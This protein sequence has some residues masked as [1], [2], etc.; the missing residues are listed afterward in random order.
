MTVTTKSLKWLGA[1]LVGLQISACADSLIPATP[2]P[3]I[4]AVAGGATSRLA[5]TPLPDGNLVSITFAV[6]HADCVGGAGF[7]Y[8]IN[9]VTLGGNAATNGCSCQDNELKVTFNDPA[10]IAAWV[11]GGQNTLSV[12][13]SGAANLAVG[14][15]RAEVT[16]TVGSAHLVVFDAAP[17]GDA[18]RRDVCGGFV[19]VTDPISRT[20]EPPPAPP[21]GS[22]LS[23]SYFINHADCNDV[24]QG[25]FTFVLNGVTLGSAATNATCQC[26][27]GELQVTFNGPDARA[28][29]HPLAGNNSEVLVTGNQVAVGYIRVSV[30]TA[31]GTLTAPLYDAIPHGTAQ[32]R[33]MCVAYELSGAHGPFRTTFTSGDEV[34]E[35]TDAVPTALAGPDQVAACVD[36]GA[37]IHLD[38]SLSSDP[39]NEVLTYKWFAGASVFSTL[40]APT[41]MVPLGQHT[42]TLEVAD[43]AGQTHRDDVVVTV[44]DLVAPAVALNVAT[45]ELW[46]ANGKMEL[47]ASGVGATDACTSTGLTLSVGVSSNEP[48]TGHGGPKKSN[49]WEVRQN[50]N[51]TYDVYV[52]AEREG[53]GNGRV[54]TIT[55]TATDAAGNATTRTGTVTVPKSQGKKK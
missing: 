33:D 47:V 43:P 30:V 50:A 26:N 7:S 17:G 32:N 16:T 49:D 15:I 5:L 53:K 41:K 27:S 20:F 29:W 2:A 31:G 14:Y 36:G 25:S 45:S 11:S 46:P 51:G 9:G 23:I 44:T 18:E 6:G 28:A 24:A 40:A 12:A 54:Y 37:L 39:L 22:L 52:R 1:V 48:P 38:G 19:R 35:D 3:G 21:A 4:S 8:A 10:T 13:F 55:A 42:L 34:D